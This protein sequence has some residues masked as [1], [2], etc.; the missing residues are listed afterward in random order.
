MTEPSG[1]SLPDPQQ[2]AGTGPDPGPGAA[3]PAPGN[4]ETPPGSGQPPGYGPRPPS[5]YGQSPPPGYGTPPGQP[6][7]YPPPGYPPPGYP[8]PPGDPSSYGPAPVWGAGPAAHGRK[9]GIVPLRPLALGEILDGGFQAIRSNPKTMI[10][11]AAIVL[12]TSSVLMILPQAWL[13]LLLGRTTAQ[14]GDTVDPAAVMDA[15]AAS[16]LATVPGLLVTQLATTVLSAMLVV[17]VSGAVIGEKTA[18]GVLWRRVRRRVPAAIGLSLLN[19]LIVL[20]AVAVV[21]VPAA[22]SLAFGPLALTVVLGILGAI[23]AFV[24]SFT[25]TTRL[26]LAAPALLLEER[27][28]FS[29][30]RRSWGLIRGSF[31][32]TLLILFLAGLIAGFGAGVISVPFSLVAV[33]IQQ[34]TDNTAHTSFGANLAETATT[35]VGQILAGAVFTPWN[36]AVIALV[37]IDIR[38]RREGLDLELIKAADE[39]TGS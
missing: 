20:L 21:F 33:I 3:S 13:Q 38:M 16:A 1:W 24:V 23:G 37:Y 39:Q 11:V 36:A 7:G 22:L 15:S 2:G 17:A 25:L 6:P 34:V 8:P 19:G 10:G 26:A 9:P 12:A 29:A 35:S 4:G 27:G 18:P 14:V 28:V 5:P 31:W 30:I 32:R